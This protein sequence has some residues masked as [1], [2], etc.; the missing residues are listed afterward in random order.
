MYRITLHDGTVVENLR[1]NGDT[2]ISDTAVDKSIFAGNLKSLT[3]EGGGKTETHE[4]WKLSACYE[5]DGEW[6][7]CLSPKSEA[8]LD[9]EMVMLAIAELGSLVAG[10]Y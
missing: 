5:Q 9:R 4:N 3:I 7:V 2:F 8:E 10:G 1:L 6:N